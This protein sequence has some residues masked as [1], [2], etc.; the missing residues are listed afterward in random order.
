MRKKGEDF[1]FLLPEGRGRI[2]MRREAVIS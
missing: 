1:I 2:T